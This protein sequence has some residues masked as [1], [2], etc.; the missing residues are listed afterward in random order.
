MMTDILAYM[1][2]QL[3]ALS[4]PYE[5]GEWTQDIQYPYFVGS[6]EPITPLDE[7]GKVGGTF[8]LD[9]FTRH[10]TWMELYSVAETIKSN[11]PPV[12]GKRA[13]LSDGSG[14]AVFYDTERPVPT[15]DEGLRK[16]EIRLTVKHWN[17]G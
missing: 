8:I 14:I 15:G 16:L 3:T 11:F 4:V 12:G 1:N 9:G 2:E 10:S 17:V 5:F 7:D 13:V 6:Y